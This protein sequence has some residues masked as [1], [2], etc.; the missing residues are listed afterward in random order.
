MTKTAYYIKLNRQI[1]G[2][3]IIMNTEELEKRLISKS[4]RKRAS[5]FKKLYNFGIEQNADEEEDYGNVNRCVRTIYSCFS[6][7]PSS[8][9]YE[10]EKN[11]YPVIGL[12]D[13]ASLGGAEELIKAEAVSGT[14]YYIG[15]EVTVSADGEEKNLITVAALGV[16]HKH[17]KDFHGDLS[18][19]RDEESR[20][21]K[22]LVDRIN[23]R[24]KP[25]GIKIDRPDRSPFLKIHATMNEKKVYFDLAWAITARY[26][27]GKSVIDF[28][29]DDMGLSLSISEKVALD[30]YLDENYNYTLANVLSKK[31]NISARKEKR[32]GVE[33]F[34]NLCEIYGAIPCLI[35]DGENAENDIEIA[36]KNG[37]KA[38]CA[39]VSAPQEYLEELYGIAMGNFI[40]P[41]CREII[42]Y[43]D[44][45]TRPNK[46][47]EDL[48]EKYNEC[49][50]AL[51]GHEIASSIHVKDGLFSP[52]SIAKTPDFYERIKLY[53][54]IAQ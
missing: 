37:L 11:G 42:D 24:F 26:H 25:F 4:R 48:A 2:F 32:T 12:V 45:N 41:L 35:T 16:P 44:K 1:R 49:V 53:S 27:D 7:T 31:L 33:Y 46:M 18:I 10:A 28:L 30:N 29:T 15:A 9:A 52:S 19:F 51:I 23:D 3:Y 40:L 38:V 14:H 21:I 17:I 43:T 50:F 8:A 36:K 54:R 20:R 22:S 34:L 5:A 6:R 13:H 39:D 47:E